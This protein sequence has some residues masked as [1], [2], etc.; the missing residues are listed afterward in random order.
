MKIPDVEMDGAGNCL[1]VEQFLQLSFNIKCAPPPPP[2]H[3]RDNVSC[4][5]ISIALLF[6]G[7]C[8]CVCIF[9]TKDCVFDFCHFDLEISRRFPFS[10]NG[11]LIEPP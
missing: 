6:V 8:D 5:F 11:K 10:G 1:A 9:L 3:P 7:D 2:L 4:N